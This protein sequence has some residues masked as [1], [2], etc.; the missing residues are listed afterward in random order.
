MTGINDDEI[1]LNNT[2]LTKE[3][4]P[5][6]GTVTLQPNKLTSVPLF[7]RPPQDTHQRENQDSRQLNAKCD[8][9]QRPLNTFLI[10]HWI[11]LLGK[12]IQP[13]GF[14]LWK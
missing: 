4:I 10:R 11:S 13:K 8:T 1:K 14:F 5:E 7:A 2:V 12:S 3:S 9:N 6:E